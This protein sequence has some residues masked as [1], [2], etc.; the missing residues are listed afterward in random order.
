MKGYLLAILWGLVVWFFAILFFV[1]FGKQVLF[2]PGSHLFIVS[3][4][5]LLAGTAIL[6]LV[7]T[8]LYVM[9]DRSENSALKFG[10]IGTIVG[11][12]LDTFSLAN[13]RFIFP[14]LSESQIIAFTVWMSFAYALY[15]IIPVLVN[16]QRRK[17]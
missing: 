5:I 12:I 13:H 11:L 9:F 14:Q 17:V 8:F 1:I 3:T 10:V 2:T 6:L 7:I 4:V 16:E 15:L